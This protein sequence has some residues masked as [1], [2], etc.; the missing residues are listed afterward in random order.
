MKYNIKSSYEDFFLFF[1]DFYNIYCKVTIII[2]KKGN[3]Y[4]KIKH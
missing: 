3:P 4:E 2:V 1:I